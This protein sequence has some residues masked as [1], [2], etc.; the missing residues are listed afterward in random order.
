MMLPCLYTKLTETRG[1]GVFTETDIEAGVV[2]E[3]S[4]VIV[5]S[6]EEKKWLD[7]T[8]LFNYIFHWQHDQCCMAMGLVPVYNHSSAANCEYFQDYEAGTIYIQTMRDIEAGEE[9]FINYN[10]AWDNAEPVWF[11]LK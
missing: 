4:P 8:S 3:V 6:A 2:I 10:G 9:L 1:W 5:M 11:D 7:Q